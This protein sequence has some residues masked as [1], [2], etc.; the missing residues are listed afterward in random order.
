MHFTPKEPVSESVGYA[1]A[2]SSCK[3]AG[4][5]FR[6]CGKL[7]LRVDV[8]GETPREGESQQWQP[9]NSRYF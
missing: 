5:Q 6:R 1:V 2:L 4:P 3:V 9:I 8:S 7:A